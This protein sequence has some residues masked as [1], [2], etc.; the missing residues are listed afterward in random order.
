MKPM[1]MMKTILT[2]LTIGGTNFR[3]VNTLIYLLYDLIQPFGCETLFNFP[4]L[5]TSDMKPI[6]SPMT[7]F[8]RVTIYPYNDYSLQQIGQYLTNP[9]SFRHR[10][11]Q[12]TISFPQRCYRML[13]VDCSHYSM[14]TTL[15]TFYQQTL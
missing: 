12:L 14:P 7:P 9:I 11:S 5:Q 3:P 6:P 8:I 13:F 2:L 4:F 1:T 15:N 10:T